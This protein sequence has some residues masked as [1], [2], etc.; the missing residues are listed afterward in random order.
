MSVT[1]ITS[2]KQLSA[3]Q[4]SRMSNAQPSSTQLNLFSG[5]ALVQAPTSETLGSSCG[6][7]SQQCVAV[8]SSK[9]SLQLQGSVR[10]LL[11]MLRV[12]S[13]LNGVEAHHLTIVCALF[14]SML[15]RQ[16]GSLPLRL[17]GLMSSG[18]T[19]PLHTKLRP[20]AYGLRCDSRLKVC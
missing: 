2:T 20:M 13:A 19:L 15:E 7:P 17:V 18:K 16:P 4:P 1:A 6:K 9:A 12:S 3:F 8:S 14:S 10:V 5:L 11:L